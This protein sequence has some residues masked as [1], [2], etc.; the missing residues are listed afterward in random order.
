MSLLFDYMCVRLPFI[1]W[2]IVGVPSSQALPGFLITAPPPV[3]VPTVLGTLAVWV[4]NQKE[5]KRKTR[6]GGDCYSQQRSFNR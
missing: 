2:S 5:R 1:P 6:R 3:L 4:Q